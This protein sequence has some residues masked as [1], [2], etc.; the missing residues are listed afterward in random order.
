MVAGSGNRQKINNTIK[1][2]NYI[3]EGEMG[4]YGVLFKR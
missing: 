2:L 4:G 3:L 1:L